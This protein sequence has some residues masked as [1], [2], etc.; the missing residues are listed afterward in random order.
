MK[1]CKC[2]SYNDSYN[3]FVGL[4]EENTGNAVQIRRPHF[5]R[6]GTI[7]CLLGT[8]ENIL[9]HIEPLIFL[10]L[11][12]HH[13]QLIYNVKEQEGHVKALNF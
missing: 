2:D 13:L 4:Q 9:K 10:L 1:Q 7:H 3:E 12:I 6:T 11:T 8:V 5:E